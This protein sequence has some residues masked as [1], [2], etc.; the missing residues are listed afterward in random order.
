MPDDD[1]RTASVPDVTD[2]THGTHGTD[3]TAGPDG[4]DAA[5][6]HYFTARPASADERRTLDVRLAGRDVTVETAGGVFS[7]VGS[8]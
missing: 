7:P 5:G 4:T 6:D 1:P 3:G 8:T 2:G